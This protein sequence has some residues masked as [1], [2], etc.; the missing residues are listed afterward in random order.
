MNV[1]NSIRK[2]LIIALFGFAM[3]SCGSSPG[4]ISG[5]ADDR[6]SS[7]IVNDIVDSFFTVSWNWKTNGMDTLTSFKIYYDTEPFFTKSDARGSFLTPDSSTSF[8]FDPNAYSIDECLTVY[9]SVTA[10]GQNSESD[11]TANKSFETD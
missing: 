11:L 1:P 6:N 9:I 7:C 3:A 4:G 8:I 10:I 2:G 5:A